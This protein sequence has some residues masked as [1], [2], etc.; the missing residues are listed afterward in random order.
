MIL[1]V[2]V[3]RG[4]AGTKVDRTKEAFL[5]ICLFELLECF[6]SRQTFNQLYFYPCL[7]V[8]DYS[9]SIHLGLKSHALSTIQVSARVQ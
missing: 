9:F 7:L 8:E 2:E 4:R 5:L 3:V 6:G 1:R